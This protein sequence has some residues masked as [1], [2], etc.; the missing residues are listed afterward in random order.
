MGLSTWKN[1]PDGRILSSDVSIAK[2]YL[3]EN[4][5]KRLERTISGFFDY[6]EN[7]IEN[8]VA[9]SMSDMAESVDKFLSFN[10]YQLLTHKGRVS[11]K[12]AKSKALEEY[13]EFNKTQK[14]NSDFEKVIKSLKKG[15][16]L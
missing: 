11:H 2:N 7:I 15:D 13:A 12:Q 16:K 3:D 4:L 6:I 10:E 1:A 5:I 14:I 9:M 8:R